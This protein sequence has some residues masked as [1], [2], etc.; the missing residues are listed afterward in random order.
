MSDLVLW[1]PIKLEYLQF[2]KVLCCHEGGD[3]DRVGGVR[4][5]LG[6]GKSGQKRS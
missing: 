5:G 4:V 2:V 1:V 6:G 3:R